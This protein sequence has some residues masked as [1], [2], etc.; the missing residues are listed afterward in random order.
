M[1]KIVVEVSHTTFSTPELILRK[2]REVNFLA[3]HH[4]YYNCLYF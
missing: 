3:F 1:K 2:W 4:T